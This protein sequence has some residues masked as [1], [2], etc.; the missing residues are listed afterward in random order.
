MTDTNCCNTLK[1]LIVRWCDTYSICISCKHRCEICADAW[2]ACFLAHLRWVHWHCVHA[3]VVAYT[4]C[5]LSTCCLSLTNHLQ[6]SSQYTDFKNSRLWFMKVLC[7]FL[8][9][10]CVQTTQHVYFHSRHN[11]F[12]CSV[13][14]KN[15]CFIIFNTA[16]NI[17]TSF[18]NTAWEENVFVLLT[19]RMGVGYRATFIRYLA[20]MGWCFNAV[21]QTP[22]QNI[23]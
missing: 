4:G 23:S 12:S 11:G 18:H 3:A 9:F 5:S 14:W 15:K 1:R 13:H 16:V 2:E 21:R 10:S 22:Q 7:N 17:C 19:W 6:F 20:G 8:W